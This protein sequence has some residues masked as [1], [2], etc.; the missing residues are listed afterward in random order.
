VAEKK[1]PAWDAQAAFWLKYLAV[2]ISAAIA[3][4]WIVTGHPL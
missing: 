3:V 4:N 1:P 2:V